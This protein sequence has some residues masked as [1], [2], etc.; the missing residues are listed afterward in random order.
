MKASGRQV[1]RRGADSV[2]AGV[3]FRVG[4]GWVAAAAT[5]KGVAFVSLPCGSRAAGVRQLRRVLPHA[6]CEPACSQPAGSQRLPGMTPV[7]ERLRDQLQRYFS[8]RAV[9]FDVPLDPA[10]TAFQKKI[11]TLARKVPYG[12]VRS[13]G[14]L[15]RRA[16]GGARDTGQLP[17]SVGQALGRNPVPVLVP[18]HRIICSDGSTGGYSGGRGWKRRLLSLER[19][20]AVPGPGPSVS[21][22]PSR[23]RSSAGCPRRAARRRA[24]P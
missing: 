3:V 15:A 14:W 17:R 16:A 21:A 8:G 5:A 20:P 13:Y 23:G 6:G 19:G 4:A 7:F 1:P 18:C 11:W 10:G 22:R 24:S 12:Q 9:V 2:T